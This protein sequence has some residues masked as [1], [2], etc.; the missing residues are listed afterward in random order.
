MCET[1]LDLLQESDTGRGLEFDAHDI[2]VMTCLLRELRDLTLSR[3]T[4][5][6]ATRFLQR[7]TSERHGPL[8]VAHRER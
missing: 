2:A 4:F 5:T 7:M 6:E 8:V 3:R 1:K